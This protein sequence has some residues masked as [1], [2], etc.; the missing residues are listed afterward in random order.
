MAQ[1]TVKNIFSLAVHKESVKF[2][3]I[4]KICERNALTIKEHCKCAIEHGI[5]N[6]RNKRIPKYTLFVHSSCTQ[7]LVSHIF[8]HKKFVQVLFS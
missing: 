7:N 6:I 8:L 4:F 3:K 2:H 5:R 1:C